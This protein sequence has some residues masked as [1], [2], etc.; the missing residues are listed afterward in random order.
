MSNA[1]KFPNKEPEVHNWT[2]DGDDGPPTNRVDTL[3]IQVVDNGY[4]L[5]GSFL[6][7]DV[8]SPQDPSEPDIHEVFLDNDSLTKRIKE[9]TKM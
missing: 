8:D 2:K 1:I 4:I 5:T 3:L 9:L 6:Y 7:V